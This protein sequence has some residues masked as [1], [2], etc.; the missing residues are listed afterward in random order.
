MYLAFL[1]MK[2]YNKGGMGMSRFSEKLKE[3]VEGCGLSV[4]EL[5]ARTGM[6]A[7]VLYKFQS[8]SRMPDSLQT[9]FRLLDVMVCSAPQSR[10]L[11]QSYQ[12]ERIGTD[13]YL[14]FQA[15][16]G[17]LEDIAWDL[18]P[19]VETMPRAYPAEIPSAVRGG[20]NVNAVVRMILEQET[21]VAGGSIVIQAPLS[22]SFLMEAL[23]QTL[24]GCHP[25]FGSVRHRFHLRANA[26]GEA[27]LYNMESI[28]IVLPKMF[29]RKHYDPFYCYLDDPD[30]GTAVFP[31]YILTLSGV[32]L[33]SSDFQNA[34]FI[35]DPLMVSAFRREVELVSKAYRP[36]L[37]SSPGTFQS[38]I[39]SHQAIR[40]EVGTEVRPVSLA[41]Q[42]SVLPYM[43]VERAFKYLPESI[44]SSKEIRAMAEFFFQNAEA[45]GHTVFCSLEGVRYLM[46]TGRIMEMLGPGIPTFSREDIRFALE[47]MV[48]RA[49]AGIVEIHLFR[50]D[51]FQGTARISMGL[52]GS[53]LFTCCDMP[54]RGAVFADATEATLCH[55]VR[56]YLENAETLG[57]V[58]SAEESI[59]LLESVLREYRGQ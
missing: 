38:Y 57:D 20:G 7:S 9:L 16:K 43:G 33:L 24:P 42:P 17:L 6:S 25:E 58:F 26:T 54:E 28:R 47:Q 10:E 46:E 11:I 36:I 3:A 56:D 23:N 19:P 49:R 59:G 2:L 22:Y 32:L 4:G 29:T 37:H 27:L 14:C 50:Q 44:R 15:L 31:Y 21:R 12:I 35:E 41:Y 55:V 13:R 48:A 39:F 45:N 8:G 30:D 18:N 40:H 5:A 51:I 53:K 1:I 52:Y 34:V